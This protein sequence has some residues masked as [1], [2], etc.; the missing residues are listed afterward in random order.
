[1]KKS[2]YSTRYFYRGKGGRF[3][4]KGTKGAKREAH[5]FDLETGKHFSGK[6]KTK[7]KSLLRWQL[8]FPQVKTNKGLKNIRHVVSSY[9][10]KK[11]ELRKIFEARYESLIDYLRTAEPNLLP[12]EL[13]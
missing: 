13:Q 12:D 10:R 4:K 1:M 9:K 6:L 5:F 8:A 11:G 7:N 3:V 2:P